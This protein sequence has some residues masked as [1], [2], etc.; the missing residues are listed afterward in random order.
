MLL[1]FFCVGDGGSSAVV[2]AVGDGVGVVN[3][4]ARIVVPCEDVV[5]VV[6]AVVVV[7]YCCCCFLLLVLLLLLFF[8]AVVVIVVVVAFYCCWCW[9]CCLR[10]W[11]PQ[12]S[13]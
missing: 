13:V 3:P 9:C 11:S 7:F 6:I 2:G 5:D 4:V 10:L 8:T 1:L 12:S